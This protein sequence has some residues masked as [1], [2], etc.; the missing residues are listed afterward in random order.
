[1]LNDHIFTSCPEKTEEFFSK[2]GVRACVCVGGGG[3]VGGGGGV[4]VSS[5]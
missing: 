3:R 5:A 1:M 2:S 4:G